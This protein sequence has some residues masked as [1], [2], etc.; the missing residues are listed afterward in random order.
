VAVFVDA[1]YGR[2][3]RSFTLST[4]LAVMGAAGE[5]DY[6]TAPKGRAGVCDV[7]ASAR[8]VPIG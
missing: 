3:L 6:G 4:N 7:V 8:T 5:P 1:G 2:L